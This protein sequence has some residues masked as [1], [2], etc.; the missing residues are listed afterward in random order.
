[1]SVY[2]VRH[3]QT[4]A[5]LLAINSDIPIVEHDAPLNSTGIVQAKQAAEQLKSSSVSAIISSPMTRARETAEIINQYHKL[6]IIIDPTFRERE[7]GTR[8]YHDFHELFD[9]D[10]NIQP[11]GG[12]NAR[13][14]FERIYG[15]IDKVKNEFIDKDIL[16][17]AHG[18]V[19]HGFYAYFNSLP[20][21]G[22]LRISPIHNAAIRKYKFNT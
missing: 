13:D 16:I 14:F 21:Q 3:G 18:G 8:S 2:F 17:V 19:H 22:N 7:T 1:M 4:D 5:N 6:P 10:K 11:L 20:W 9:I 15:G 12:E